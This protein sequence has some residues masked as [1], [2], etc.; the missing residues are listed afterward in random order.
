MR[1]GG[2]LDAVRLRYPHAPE[3]WIDLSTG[4]DPLPYPVPPVAADAW[5]RLPTSSELQSLLAAAARRYGAGDIGS[6][7]AAPGTQ[8]LIQLLPRLTPRTR[9]AILGPTYDEH[10]LCWRRHAHDVTV[11][12]TLDAALEGRARVVVIVN[13][14]NPTG[15]LVPPADLAAAAE[16]LARTDGLLVV[17]EAFVDVLPAGA[18]VVPDLPPATVVLRSFG[19]T[20]GLA[21]VRL[22]FAV[23]PADLATRMR[24]ALGPWAVSGP[25][26]AIG[27]RALADDAW[28]AAATKRLTAGARRMDDL[29]RG[30]GCAIVGGTPL[31]RLADH[32]DAAT[33]A[34]RLGR[35]GI[36][37]RTFSRN[38]RWLRLGLPGDEPAWQRLARALRDDTGSEGEG[39]GPLDP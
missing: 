39:P 7:V 16:R 6:I 32:T 24:A 30:A 3:P 21:G 8:A 2:D 36:H 19:K 15:R 26:I 23:A 35:A 37:V 31:F 12:D 18:S 20:Y 27:A 10:E 29:L 9:V 25:A 1:H 22:G 34:Q 14:N 13:P 28:L 38:A 5:A 33:L 11:T 4:I 17:D